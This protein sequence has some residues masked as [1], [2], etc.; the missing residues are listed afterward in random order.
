M[1]YISLTISL[2][3]ITSNILNSQNTEKKIDPK[4]EVRREFD[5]N[6]PDFQKSRTNTILADS[7]KQFNMNVEYNLINK[8]I[9]DLYIFSPLPSTE[10]SQNQKQKYP[11]LFTQIGMGFPITPVFD[12][13]IH[14]YLGRGSALQIYF[15]HNSLLGNIKMSKLNEENFSIPSELNVNA[16]NMKNNAGFNFGKFWKNGEAVVKFNYKK[17]LYSYYGLSEELMP[18]VFLI[19]EGLDN[20]ISLFEDPKFVKDSLSH[21]YD[22][23]SAEIIVRSTQSNPKSLIYNFKVAGSYLRDTAFLFKRSTFGSASEKNLSINATLGKIIKN[24]N[25]ILTSFDYVAANS[26]DSTTL[27]RYNLQIYPH[28]KFSD[29][30]INLEAGVKYSLLSDGGESNVNNIFLR[31][32]LNYEAVK[33]SLWLYASINGYN[34]FRTLTSTLADNPWIASGNVVIKSGATP[35]ELN[36]GA[37]LQSRN[38]FSINLSG[39]LSK[40]ENLPFHYHYSEQGIQIEIEQPNSMLYLG[41]YNGTKYFADAEVSFN[42]KPINAKLSIKYQNVI[43]E[44]STPSYDITPVS[45]NLSLRYSIRDRIFTGIDVMYRS[46][47]PAMLL[48][49][50]FFIPSFT[51]IDLHTDYV[52]DKN[53]SFYLKI[54]NILNS[55]EQY[56][57]F[58]RQLGIH[59]STG[60]YLK[61]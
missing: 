3:I 2:I 32:N 25:I 59:V 38:R 16:Q 42:Y 49:E 11:F 14:P 7:V 27:N 52:Y 50:E 56:Y 21:S 8:P 31:A 4:L 53:L 51:R 58:Y 26:L 44:G 41:Y 45:A 15:D 13:R 6:L 1:K 33:N 24:K 39:G 23:I 20:N 12:L 54:D 47:T 19:S 5:G 28:Y 34:H 55:N 36:F 29:K 60:I 18:L 17:D 61:F 35:L 48:M 57:L 22:K 40:V 10:I 37:I 43:T 30:R 46:K 9:R